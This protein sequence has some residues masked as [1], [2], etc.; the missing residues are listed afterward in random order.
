VTQKVG[1][2]EGGK[3]TGVEIGEAKGKITIRA[4][5]N[6][7]EKKI[8][9]GDYV[10]RKTITNN[11]L[12]LGP[13]ALDEIAKR[14]AEAQGV[15][16]QTLQ[17]L[18]AQNVPENVGR[19]I[20]EVV[21]AQK[22][23]AS[24]GLSI[25][26]PVAYR[27][28]MLA[29]YNRDYDSALAYF[30]QATEIDS[31]YSDAF[32]AISWLQQSRAMD[33]FDSQNYSAA[34]EKLN[35]ARSAAMHTDPLDPNA[36]SQRGYVSKT[37]AQISETLNDQVNR[38]KYYEEAAKLFQHVIKLQPNNPGARNGLGNIE[39]ALGN[40]DAAIANYQQ[41]IDLLPYYTAAHHD[42]ALAFEHKMENDPTR[43]D[44]WCQK[45]ILEWHKTYDLAPND[46]GFSADSIQKINQRITWLKK[47]CGKTKRKKAKG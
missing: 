28:G 14:L 13:Q 12:V 15:D 19:Q 18:G 1:T 20:T 46:P 40:I 33:D 5:V 24:R 45:A 44:D 9:N 22:E 34:L 43:K 23:V 27:L 2:V 36:L 21:A 17:N 8:V 3:V 30:R 47:R 11:I 37:L 16:K 39:H 4:T 7:I 29:A 41:A 32:E 6:Q 25:S 10:D 26:P 42:L 38:Q 31:D 35:D